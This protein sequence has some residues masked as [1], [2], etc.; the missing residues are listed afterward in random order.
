[1]HCTSSVRVQSTPH[2]YLSR[3]L[4]LSRAAIHMWT[5]VYDYVLSCVLF[6]NFFSGFIEISES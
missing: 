4:I 6:F 3:P 2:T 5:S 1:M